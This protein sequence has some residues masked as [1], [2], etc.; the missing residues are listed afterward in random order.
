MHSTPSQHPD[1]SNFADTIFT[2][3]KVLSLDTN[4]TQT[5]AIAVRGETILALGDDTGIQSL[6][7]Q[8]TRRID[9]RGRLLTPGLIDGHAHMDREGLKEAL[10]TL[11]GCRSIDDVLQRIQAL[12]AQT[13]VGEWIV[14]MPI[15][16]PPFYENVPQCLVEG[17]FP[18]RWELDRVAPNHPVYIRA[19]WGHW[20]NTLP[21]VSVANSC[22]LERAGLDRA[23]L[24]PS[25]NIHIDK[26]HSTGE[27]TGILYE[28]TYKP[29]VEKTLMRCIPPFN[30]SQRLQGLRRSMDIY[31]GYGTTSVFEGHGI[32][33]EVMSAY[34][35]LRAEGPL[36][37]RAALM[38]SP[39]WTDTNMQTI[40]LF[41]EDWGR[42]LAG[43]GLGD[44][45]LR[46]AGLFTESDY[47]EENSLR[48]MCRPYTGWAGFNFNAALPREIMIDMMVE[49]A[50]LGIQ[51]GSF[52]DGV[53]GLFEQVN[54]REP[55][56]QQRWII[57]HIG[58]LND[59][60][61]KRARDLGVV[62][63][64]YTNKW[65]YQ[66][67]ERLRAQHGDEF[68]E[69]IVPLRALIDA[70]VHVSLAT[71]NVP[72]TLM[73]PIW[74]AVA[75]RTEEAN[76]ILGPG[77]KITRT[78]ALAAASREGAYLSFEEQQKGTLEPGKFA[79]L[80][81]WNENPLEIE[82]ALLPTVTSDLTM[83]GGRIVHE[84]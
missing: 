80:C 27:P 32:A 52:D 42:W 38:F 12:A 14:T 16:E 81:V 44:V 79:D 54:R 8:N 22:A 5:S 15:G 20:R 1:L 39:A 35:S 41:L 2:N 60:D 66:D 45:Y 53:L 51:V 26:C 75:R 19:I 21:L 4:S 78:E 23:T 84:V 37:V 71:D 30:A 36:P 13:P 33:T 34:Q 61:I 67:G 82:E 77:Q 9:L 62:M 24:S 6:T 48:S 29:L 70:G 3:G 7:D 83:T 10:P 73:A 63:Q 58:C 40:K 46:V 50:R 17:R 59:D 25:A 57:E 68:T 31:A 69:T 56:D 64:A 47:C 28:Y 72:P 18:T 65:I 74:H 11:S 49:A 76:Q 55:I 43:R